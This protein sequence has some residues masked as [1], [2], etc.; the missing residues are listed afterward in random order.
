ML[1]IVC[2]FIIKYFSCNC[3]IRKTSVISY[4]LKI[5]LHLI[6]VVIV[7]N[8]FFRGQWWWMQPHL[9]LIVFLASCNLSPR[10]SIPHFQFS[11]SLRTSKQFLSICMHFSS[12]TS[13][14]CLPNNPE[15]FLP[16]SSPSHH[17][18]PSVNLFLFASPLAKLTRWCLA[19]LQFH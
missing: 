13:S 19:S 16:P 4:L 12:K 2:G 15:L 1:N 14:S 18:T 9:L 7:P 10:T 6:Q 3:L 11:V 8:N 17:P 5:K